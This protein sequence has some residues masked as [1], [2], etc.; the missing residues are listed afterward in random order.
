[1]Q[2]T[3]LLCGLHF[4]GTALNERFLPHPLPWRCLTLPLSHSLPV[5]IALLL[6][7]LCLSLAKQVN[8][9]RYAPTTVPP[10]SFTSLLLLPLLLP[11]FAYAKTHTHTNTICLAIFFRVSCHIWLL[12][13]QQQPAEEPLSSFASFFIASQDL[14]FYMHD[15]FPNGFFTSPE[16]GYG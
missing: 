12:E 13:Q 8:L 15:A 14:L 16:M 2:L 4:W 7:V 5:S 1:M 9:L 11:P 3:L 6:F 10:S